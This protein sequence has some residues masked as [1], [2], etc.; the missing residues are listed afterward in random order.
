[1][2]YIRIDSFYLIYLIP[3][4]YIKKQLLP[5]VLCILKCKLFSLMNFIIIVNSKKTPHIKVIIGKCFS[6]SPTQFKYCNIN[7]SLFV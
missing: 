7:I 4:G 1:M 2:E 3:Q 5:F 6:I